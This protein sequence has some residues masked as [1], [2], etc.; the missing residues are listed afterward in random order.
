MAMPVKLK[1]HLNPIITTAKTHIKIRNPTRNPIGEDGTARA[2]SIH[3]SALF[4]ASLKIVL[5]FFLSL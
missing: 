3:T 1:S 2:R 4:D 5:A